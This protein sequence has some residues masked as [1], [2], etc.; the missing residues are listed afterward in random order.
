MPTSR[1]RPGKFLVVASGDDEAE[2][3]EMC[4]WYREHQRH[5]EHDL[6]DLRTEPD[7]PIRS[8]HRYHLVRFL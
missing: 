2:L 5:E 8:V 3:W 4:R 6:V 7:S 1:F